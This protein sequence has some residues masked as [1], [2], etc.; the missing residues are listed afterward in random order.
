MKQ[1]ILFDI[2]VDKRLKIRFLLLKLNVVPLYNPNIT[3]IRPCDG[4]LST[5]AHTLVNLLA[6]KQNVHA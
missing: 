3:Y 1:K 5:S 6:L 2:F 4:G